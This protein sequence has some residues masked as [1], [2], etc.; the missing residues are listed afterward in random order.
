M[1]FVDYDEDIESSIIKK[2]NVNDIGEVDYWPEH[3]FD[4]SFVETIALKVAQKENKSGS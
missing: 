2:I 3:I 1:C 4:E